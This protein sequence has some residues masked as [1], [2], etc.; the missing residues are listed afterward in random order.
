MLWQREAPPAL[1]PGLL[2]GL[3]DETFHLRAHVRAG[4][5]KCTRLPRSTPATSLA[6]RRGNAADG[7][8]VH[9]VTA[10]SSTVSCWQMHGEAT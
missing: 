9:S 5:A 10:C 6:G 7:C 1:V 8:T 2:G 3:A 4:P